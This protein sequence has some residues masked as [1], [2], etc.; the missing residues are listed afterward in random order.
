LAYPLCQYVWES[1]LDLSLTE[2]ARAYL[3]ASWLANK[4]G[5]TILPSAGETLV[6]GTGQGVFIRKST[7][8]DNV[9]LLSEGALERLRRDAGLSCVWLL[10]AERNAWPG[11]SNAAATWRRAEGVAWMDGGRVVSNTWTRDGSALEVA[12]GSRTGP[13]K[14]GG[15]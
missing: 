8:E 2:G 13:R 5:W 14:R 15:K 9:V 1:H 7:E 12:K 10:V 11:G 3:P 6:D 4:V